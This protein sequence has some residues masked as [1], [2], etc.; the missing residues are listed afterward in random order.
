MAPRDPGRSLLTAHDNTVTLT[1]LEPSSGSS[2]V[3]LDSFDLAYEK[4]YK[5]IDNRLILKA[6]SHSVVTVEGFS[7]EN[8]LV[9]DITDPLKIGRILGTTVSPSDDDT[10]QAS[11]SPNNPQGR[12]LAL[13]ETAIR[14]LGGDRLAGYLAPHLM[15]SH[16]TPDYL[17]ITPKVLQ[18]EA[19]RL[20]DYRQ[21]RGL[22][23]MVVL[24]Q[25]IYD[26]FN[27]G[28][29][30]PEAVR[31]FLEYAW[32]NWNKAPRYVVRV[33]D[34][35]FDYKDIK[36]T[37]D[38][39]MP[40]LMVD[41]PWG[42]F[43]SENRLADVDGSDDGLPEMIVGLLPAD[44]NETLG[45]MIDKIIGYEATGGKWK[46]QVLMVADNAD[47]AGNFPKDSDA[48]AALVPGEFTVDSIY[49]NELG[50]AASRENLSAGLD[51]G[52][53]LMNYL[54]HA[55]PS[56]LAQE[57]IWTLPDVAAMTNTDRLPILLGM[58]C[59]AGRF[60]MPGST[61]IAEA[62]VVKP[63]GGAIASWS[64]TGLSLNYLARMLGEEFFNAVFIDQQIVLG[65]AVLSAMTAYKKRHPIGNSFMLNI[66]N[67]IGDPA[68]ILK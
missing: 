35:S 51:T 20:A 23:A 44:S 15:S 50:L 26:E 54:G 11:F 10:Y 8:I 21:G 52:V 57:G 65:D 43:A 19:R 22:T 34:G 5:A 67:L 60:E 32:Y 45:A 58:A 17:V 40:P 27:Y 66:Y 7:Q 61:A 6:E 1:A 16:H 64:A 33:G 42:L 36:G 56:R 13:A 68:L 41:T 18:D 14:T 24:L 63:D 48:I 12:Y 47:N 29:A 62:M 25:D 30:N 2:I 9:Y 4:A 38:T 55:T 53:F 59:L 39:L 37:G 31:D 49:L 28:I 3:Y 46:K